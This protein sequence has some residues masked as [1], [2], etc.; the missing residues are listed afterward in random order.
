LLDLPIYTLGCFAYSLPWSPSESYSHLRC[1]PY[2]RREG[3]KNELATSKVPNPVGWTSSER[4]VTAT[5]AE[6]KGMAT[7]GIKCR[8]PD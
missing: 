8:L 4:V 3:H 1:G 5:H 6:S 7:V 2:Y